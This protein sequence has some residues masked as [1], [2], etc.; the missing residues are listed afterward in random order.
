MD[1]I[2]ARTEGSMVVVSIVDIVGGRGV[3]RGNGG[4]DIRLGGGDDGV[5]GV[6]VGFDCVS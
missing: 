4:D 5:L 3:G 6:C 2:T 1:W